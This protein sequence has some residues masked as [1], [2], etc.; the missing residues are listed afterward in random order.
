MLLLWPPLRLKEAGLAAGFR[1]VSNVKTSLGSPPWL[2]L[3][4][5]TLLEVAWA[6]CAESAKP[7]H[8][9]PTARS[10]RVAL[11]ARMDIWNI[12]KPPVRR[13]HPP[14]DHPYLPRDIRA[15]V[16]GHCTR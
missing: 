1:L 7:S 9:T 5:W 16:N 4:P 14:D 11:E 8:A 2:I 10:S 12:E 6:P 13:S 3:T 15:R